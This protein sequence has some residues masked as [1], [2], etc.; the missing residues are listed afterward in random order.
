MKSNSV[1]AMN[2]HERHVADPESYMAKVMMVDDESITTRLLKVFL[3]DVGYKRFVTTNR[4]PEA[5]EM[6]LEERP[7]VLLLDLQMPVVD[8][9]QILSEIREH[10]DLKHMPVLILPPFET[11]KQHHELI[12]AEP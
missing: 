1:I 9:F 4:S 5:M 10:P 7:D 2:A 12:P 11:G 3:E 8:G 6:L